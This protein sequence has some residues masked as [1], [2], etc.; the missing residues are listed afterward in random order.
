MMKML[1]DI[2]PSRYDSNTLQNTD[3]FDSE[4]NK[5]NQVSINLIDN[6]IVDN[7]SQLYDII[8]DEINKK[9]PYIDLIKQNKNKN[10][11][12]RTTCRIHIKLS[13]IDRLQKWH[14][15]KYDDNSGISKEL[16]L[17]LDEH[18]DKI[19]TQLENETATSSSFCIVYNDTTPRID[20]LKKLLEISDEL[21]N[22]SS[23]ILSKLE[24]LRIVRKQD[25]IRDSRIVKK[26]HECLQRYSINR[27]QANIPYGEYNMAGF[28]N[29]VLYLINNRENTS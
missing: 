6:S 22:N 21:K 25:G 10:C 2:K 16:E 23:Q 9:I 28:R 12:E 20:V 27:N 7:Q 5:K 19:E 17:I 11:D 8:N 15:R 13:T 4:E 29:A 14:K 24:L 18:L 3:G 1:H 26:Y